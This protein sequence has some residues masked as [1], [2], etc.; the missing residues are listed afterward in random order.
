[1]A[2]HAIFRAD[3]LAGTTQGKYLASIRM[4]TDLDNGNVVALGAYEEGAREVRT[5]TAPAKDAKIGTIAIL[6]SEEV[7]KTVKY[8]VVGNFTN[9]QNTVARGYILEAGDIFSVTA[10]AIEGTPTVGG[11][12]E[13]QANKTKMKANSTSSADATK[14]GDCIA[15]EQE[16]NITWYVFRV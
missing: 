4:T 3:N 14:I 12:V 16:G 7:D 2:N 6:G 13:L 1:M 10:E 8:D 5:Y 15:I 11:V 9:K